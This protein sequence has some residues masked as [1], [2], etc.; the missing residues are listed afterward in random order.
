MI[1]NLKYQIKKWI[2]DEHL[3]KNESSEDD[4]QGRSDRHHGD[5]KDDR[6]RASPNKEDLVKGVIPFE[7]EQP[8][9]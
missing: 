9:G 8:I 2:K 5:K 4:H 6:R 1:H 3:I 7:P